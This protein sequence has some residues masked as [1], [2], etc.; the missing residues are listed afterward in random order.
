MAAIPALHSATHD[1]TRDTHTELDI[2]RRAL[3]HATANCLN[4][5]NDN[6]SNDKGPA[7]ELSSAGP[8]ITFTLDGSR[9]AIECAIQ[10]GL[11]DAS[12]VVDGSRRIHGG[13]RGD[14]V[15]SGG[16]R[17]SGRGR[18]RRAVAARAATVAAGGGATTV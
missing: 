17:L 14:F 9:L 4:R 7:K 5:F 6:R 3:E 8:C 12:L 2:M 10:A 18:S 11:H 1:R 13:S 16:S 15:S